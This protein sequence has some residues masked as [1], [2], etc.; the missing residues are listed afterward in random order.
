MRWR[1]Q[2]SG[3]WIEPNMIML[4]VG[5]PRPC[6]SLISDAYWLVVTLSGQITRLIVS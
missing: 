1:A 6:D 5:R 3:P 4:V 2:L